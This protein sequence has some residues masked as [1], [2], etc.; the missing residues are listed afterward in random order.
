ME[1]MRQLARQTLEPT[2]GTVSVKGLKEEVHIF[3][4]QWGVPHIYASSIEDLFLAE[5][6]THAQERLWQMEFTRRLAGGTLAEM[7]GEAALDIDV[8]MR[9]IG[10][11]R[12]AEEA[13]RITRREADEL[14][15]GVVAAYVSGINEFIRSHTDNPPFEFALLAWQP[16]PWSLEDTAA[17]GLLLAWELG[18]NW[19]I[20]ILR[21]ELIERLGEKRARELLPFYPAE[22]AMVVPTEDRFAD[23]ASQLLALQRKVRGSTGSEHAPQ[24]S[25]NWVVDGSKS[26]TGM[27]LLANDPHLLI[28][29]PSI[30]YEAHLV[31]PGLNVTG[32]TFPGLP[33]VLIGHNERIAW[34]MTVLPADVQDLYIERFNP[35]NPRLYLYQ[36]RWEESEVY[37]EQ[38]VV[39]GKDE[40]ITKEVTVTRHG[41]VIDSI[42]LGFSSPEIREWPGPALALRWT[43][44]EPANVLMVLQGFVRLDQAGNWEEFRDALRLMAFPSQNFV[45]ADVDGNIGYQANSL[46]PIR[47][48]G[49]GLVPVPGWTG[50]YE[51]VG[52]IPFDD[53]PSAFNPPTHFLATANNKTVHE[54]YPYLITHDWFPPHR[55]RR[56]VQLLTAKERLSIQDF[57]DM[58]ADV[59][60]LWAQELAPF[61]TSVEPQNEAE[62]QALGYLSAW[63]FR[64]DKDSVAAT[65][66]H[67]WYKKLVENMLRAT[68]GQDIYEHYFAKQLGF[69]MSHF[70]AIPDLLEYPSAYW[71]GEGS[72]SNVRKRDEL[73]RLSLGQAIEELT[74]TLGTEMSTWRWGRLHTATFRHRLGLGPPLE[75]LLNGGPVEAGGD[76][77]TVN[78]AGFEYAFGF[79]VEV[80]PSYRQ[81]IDLGDM[82]NSVSMHAPGQSGQPASEHY[83]DFLQPWARVEYHP[84]L[85]H[86][87]VIEKETREVLK[88]VPA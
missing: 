22:A 30:W 54:D 84:M 52:Y 19:G 32:A 56:I 24:G 38:F 87:D 61:L 69:A 48:K 27:P 78:V 13:V 7:V 23:V 46:I 86:R 55:V 75:E 66:F 88:L 29:T 33:A 72:E 5:G 37:S 77:T 17:C 64:M 9:T 57:M 65:V 41:P 62:R 53:L 85:F 60:S 49:Q 63:D 74:R 58:Q 82:S 31:A 14:S 12:T 45:Y 25:N 80:M 76:W 1:Q 83:R 3:R 40:P 16:S 4:D 2:S 39:R 59:C 67:V 28:G 81:I 8:F 73:V 44:H 34:G 79:G 26:V 20:E 11:R 21:A 43:G 70:L 71:L 6:Y 51:W 18:L 47:A 15:S 42:M 68:L 36:D 35:E 10:L 50:E